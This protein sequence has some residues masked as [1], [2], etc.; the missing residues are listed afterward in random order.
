MVWRTEGLFG[1][2]LGH[3][4]S[5]KASVYPKRLRQGVEADLESV[6]TEH[7]TQVTLPA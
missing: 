4:E 2:Y 3:R 7:K 1:A 5:R 6:H